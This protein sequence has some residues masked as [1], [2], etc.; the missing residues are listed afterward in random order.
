VHYAETRPTGTEPAG[1]RTLDAGGALAALGALLLL[2]S[3]FLDWYGDDDSPSAISAW[4]SFELIDLLLAALALAVVYALVAGLAGRRRVPHVPEL[5]LRAAGPVA[6]LLVVVSL[7][8]PPPLLFLSD[9]GLEAGI[10][11]ALAAAA[12]MTIGG[13]L[14]SMRISINV[15]PRD[16]PATADPAAETR[17]MTQRPD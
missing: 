7:I 4:N 12:T 8:D 9:P 5:L 13:L 1:R 2:V 15:A 6:L 17:P 3:L 14:A 10:W 11:I 16:R